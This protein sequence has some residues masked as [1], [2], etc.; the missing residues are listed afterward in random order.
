MALSFAE[1]RK[2]NKLQ[3]SALSSIQYISKIKQASSKNSRHE[4][5]LGLIRIIPLVVWGINL[6]EP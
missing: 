5:N 6:P 2:L 4:S 3:K 1:V